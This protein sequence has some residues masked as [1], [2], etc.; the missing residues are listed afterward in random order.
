LAREHAPSP[1]AQVIA[2]IELKGTETTDLNRIE[3]Q[4]FG[5]KNNQ[6]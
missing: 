1:N 5:Y 2:V 3:A 6:P 4:A